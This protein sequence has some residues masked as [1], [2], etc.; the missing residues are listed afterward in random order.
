MHCGHLWFFFVTF[1]FLFFPYLST[2]MSAFLLLQKLFYNKDY[3]MS[4]C[5]G[6]KTTSY[7]CETY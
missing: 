1:L 5:Q 4:F 3:L 6:H 7:F 2:R